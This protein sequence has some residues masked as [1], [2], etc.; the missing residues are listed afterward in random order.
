MKQGQSQSWSLLSHTLMQYIY[1]WEG[2]K[3]PKTGLFK[4]L[5]K[6]IRDAVVKYKNL[7][8]KNDIESMW[9]LKKLLFF[10][11]NKSVLE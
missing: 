10:E 9:L 11:C 4:F 6:L 1:H 2:R 8:L 3:V 7:I 5:L